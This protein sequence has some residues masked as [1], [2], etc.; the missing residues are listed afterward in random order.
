MISLPRLL[1]MIGLVLGVVAIAGS[2]AEAGGREDG[3]PPP[4][5]GEGTMR[6]A[7]AAALAQAT[8]APAPPRGSRVRR[9]AVRGAL[10]GAAAG[11]AL[12]IFAAA[13]EGEN[14]GGGFCGQCM[15]EWGAIVIPVSA[16]VGAGVGAIVGAALP[17]RQPGL[18]LAPPERSLGRRRGVSFAVR[19]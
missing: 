19:F 16:G 7:I 17:S 4:V 13:A 9:L 2:Q 5:V 14:E 6:H 11:A 15:L 12:T 18:P 8:P 3:A 10:I 1:P